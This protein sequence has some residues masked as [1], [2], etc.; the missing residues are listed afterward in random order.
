MSE[1]QL[2]FLPFN[3]GSIHHSLL[4]D[5]NLS[6]SSN[7][8]HTTT[9]GLN[10]LLAYFQPQRFFVTLT[11]FEFLAPFVSVKGFGLW[12]SQFVEECESLTHDDA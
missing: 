12:I 9:S 3:S 7:M 5:C 6:L 4:K 2:N 11:R 10:L 8:V 1:L